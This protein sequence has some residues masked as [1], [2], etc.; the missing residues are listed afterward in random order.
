MHLSLTAPRGR[1]IV[2][3][4]KGTAAYGPHETSRIQAVSSG[5]Q[6]ETRGSNP[7]KV[8]VA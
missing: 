1:Y 2:V 7:Q 4:H 3:I 6:L 5:A 8:I